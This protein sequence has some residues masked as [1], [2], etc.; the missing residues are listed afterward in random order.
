MFNELRPVDSSRPL[1]RSRWRRPLQVVALLLVTSLVVPAL[2]TEISYSTFTWWSNPSRLHWCGRYYRETPAHLQRSQIPEGQLSGENNP[3][4]VRAIGEFPPF[5]GRQILA[6]VTPK[7]A[8][9]RLSLPCA[10]G[11][12]LHSQG[13]DY[14]VYTLEGGP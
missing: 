14:I 4:P 1:R 9:D 3:F 10:M 13:D 8:R 11:L 6:S 2:A 12:Y 5:I 7:S